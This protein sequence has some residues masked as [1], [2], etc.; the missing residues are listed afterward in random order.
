MDGFRW[1]LD[2]AAL[3]FLA[4]LL[5]SVLLL[6][7]ERIKLGDA[8]LDDAEFAA[9]RFGFWADSPE[10]GTVMGGGGGGDT[11]VEPALRFVVRLEGN[12]V[13]SITHANTHSMRIVCTK[14][15]SMLVLSSWLLN[16]ST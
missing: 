6:N 11:A 12:A 4:F 7:F 5:L 9:T 1:S 8:D 13:S 10:T 2:E 15:W 14:S 16:A 3:E